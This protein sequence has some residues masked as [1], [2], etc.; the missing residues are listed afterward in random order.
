MLIDNKNELI[1]GQETTIYQYLYN[2]ILKDGK[3]D[4]A[5]LILNLIKKK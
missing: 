4:F 1:E 2:N 3:L 5:L